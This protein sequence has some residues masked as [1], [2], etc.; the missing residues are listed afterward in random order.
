M[1]IPYN[2]SHGVIHNNIVIEAKRDTVFL[3]VKSPKYCHISY[4]VIF[5]CID[6]TS[7]ATTEQRSETMQTLEF[8]ES[9]FYARPKANKS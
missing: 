3:N 1:S 6:Y 5:I 7:D 4:R 2:G 8:P 9:A